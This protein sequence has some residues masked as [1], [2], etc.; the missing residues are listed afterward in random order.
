MQRT[1]TAFVIAFLIDG[2]PQ[3]WVR[4][5]SDIA[6]ARQSARDAIRRE[7]PTAKLSRLSVRA[8]G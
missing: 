6:S 5:G 1:S 8:G 4:F 2:R 3:R 7:W